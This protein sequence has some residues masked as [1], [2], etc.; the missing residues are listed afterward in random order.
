MDPNNPSHQGA[1]GGRSSASSSTSSAQ[2]DRENLKNSSPRECKDTTHL[3]DNIVR[4]KDRHFMWSRGKQT[5]LH[6]RE[7]AGPDL[8]ATFSQEALWHLLLY[9]ALRRGHPYPE[10]G[11]LIS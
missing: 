11:H 6:L 5:P 1:L 10:A 7:E 4:R 3:Q 2:A 8:L 9:C